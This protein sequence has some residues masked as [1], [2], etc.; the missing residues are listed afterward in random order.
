MKQYEC[1]VVIVQYNPVWEKLKRTLK[2]VISQNDC[3]YE[4]II[5]DDGSRDTCFDKTRDFFEKCDFLDYRLIANESNGG[6]VKN[7]ISGIEVAKGKYVRVIAPGD[8]LYSNTTLKKIVNFMDENHAKEAFGRMAVFEHKDGE[9]K[10]VRKQVPFNLSPYKKK[11]REN[12]KKHLLVFGDNISGAS[13]TW[14]REYYLEC[15]RR[16]TGKVIYL[17]DCTNAYTVYD[18][19]EIYFI[20]EFVTWYEHGTGISTS[21]NLK[22]TSI[23]TKDWISFF[24]E[25]KDRYPHDSYI[26]RAYLYYR[27]SQKGFLLDKILK[28]ILFI[29]RYVFSRIMAQTLDDKKYEWIEKK[30]ILEYFCEDEKADD[31]ENEGFEY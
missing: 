9:I 28:N 21:N 16:I 25:M 3:E 6:T 7:I 14:D 20:D 22:W 8:M 27:M 17:E 10:I 5:A 15:L 2:S 11:Q 29:R 26:K 30:Y 12:I 23:L 31:K 19:H 24:E 13:Y 18:G 1:S 4:I